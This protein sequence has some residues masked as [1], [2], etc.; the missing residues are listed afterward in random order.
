VRP[1]V[2]LR[3]YQRKARRTDKLMLKPRSRV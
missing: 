1:A 3:R 2:L